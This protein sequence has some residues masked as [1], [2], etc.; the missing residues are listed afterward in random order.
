MTHAQQQGA[1]G[2][3]LEIWPS[4]PPA[5]QNRRILRAMS[6]DSVQPAAI[7]TGQLVGRQARI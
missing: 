3:E 7:F 2:G 6:A 5:R 4:D 1:A